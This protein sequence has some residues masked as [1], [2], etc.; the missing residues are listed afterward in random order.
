VK[1]VDEPVK[2]Q[3]EAKTVALTQADVY[4]TLVAE[5][6]DCACQWINDEDADEAM[7]LDIAGT[8]EDWQGVLDLAECAPDLL[9]ACRK[10]LAR[11]LLVAIDGA[12][13]YAIYRALHDGKSAID[14]AEDCQHG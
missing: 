11:L 5:M 14:K 1:V 8:I 7:R 10:L 9:E 4:Q 12:N 3:M 6:F 2:P 13:D